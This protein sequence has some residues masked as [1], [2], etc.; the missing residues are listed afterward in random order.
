MH[1]PNDYRVSHEKHT[2]DSVDYWSILFLYFG[3]CFLRK[4]EDGAGR[5]C[6]P[7]YGK[8]QSFIVSH[9]PDSPLA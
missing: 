2:K 7:L 8:Y 3:V 1:T 9:L 4:G 5:L 6:K